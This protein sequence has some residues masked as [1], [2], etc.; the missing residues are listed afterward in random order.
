MS[1]C[2]HVC[3]YVC[4]YV[5]ICKDMVGQLNKMM[6]YKHEMRCMYVPVCICCVYILILPLDSLPCVPYSR[7]EP[8]TRIATRSYFVDQPSLSGNCKGH[9]TEIWFGQGLGFHRYVQTRFRYD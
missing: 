7:Y 6:M 1:V 4:M 9:Q 3:M 5:C 8:S 2:M